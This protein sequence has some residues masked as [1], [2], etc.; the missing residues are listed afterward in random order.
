MFWN[1]SFN[2][3]NTLCLFWAD[4]IPGFGYL[5]RIDQFWD[6]IKFNILCVFGGNECGVQATVAFQL[7]VAAATIGWTSSALFLRYSE[8]ANFLSIVS[9]LQGPM[10]LLF[11]MLFREDPFHWQPEMHLS[12]WL[13]LSWPW[14]SYYL[15][16]TSTT[17]ARQRGH[18]TKKSQQEMAIGRVTPFWSNLNRSLEQF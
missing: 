18:S 13:R 3:L 10:L 4:I 1:S 11:R 16:Y 17:Q 8:G 9:S 15:P 5:T 12:T 7:K 14:P 6:M 2:L